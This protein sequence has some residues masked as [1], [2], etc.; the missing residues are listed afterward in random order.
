MINPTVSSKTSPLKK[1][2][3]IVVLQ[4]FF[5]L[6][7]LFLTWSNFTSLKYTILDLRT[8]YDVIFIILWLLIFLSFIGITVSLFKYSR[9]SMVFV[10]PLAIII[11]LVFI[12]YLQPIALI[13]NMREWGID[14]LDPS[15]TKTISPQVMDTVKNNPQQFVLG[16][17]LFSMCVVAVIDG[18]PFLL[19]FL[20][21]KITRI[22]T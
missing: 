12:F 20:L 15:P 17:S 22:K 1:P 16:I 8:I 14:L 9:R 11:A 10:T 5:L 19:A 2:K 3:R 7:T 4:W 6:V 13:I 18:L 21:Y